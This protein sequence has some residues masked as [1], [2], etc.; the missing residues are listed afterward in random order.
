MYVHHIH[1]YCAKAYAIAAGGRGAL[2]EGT[3][4]D[5]GLLADK[6]GCAR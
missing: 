3:A 4:I 2:A 6:H 1:T 5:L